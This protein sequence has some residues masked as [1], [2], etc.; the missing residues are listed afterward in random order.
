MLRYIRSMSFT[1]LCAL[2]AGLAVAVAQAPDVPESGSVEAIRAFTT[3]PRYLHPWVAYVPA[4]ASVPSPTGYLGHVVGAPGELSNAARIHGY[5]RALAAASP[6]VQVET[7]GRTEEGRDILLVA[8]ADEAG[9]R[10]LAAQKEALAAL[11]DPRRTT[12]EEAERL[13]ARSRPVYYFNAGL[14]ADETGSAE[15][16]MEL[17]YRLAV[18][19]MPEIQRIR[20]RVLVLI[21]PVSE[22]DGRDKM[23]DWFRR[24]LKGRTD[25]EALPRQSP[26]YWGKYVFVD[27]NR[28]AHQQAL[29]VTQAVHRMFFDY[30]PTVVHDLHEAIPLL[31]TWNGTGPFNPHID[32]IVISEMFALSFEEVRRMTAA[33]MPGVWTWD[34]GEGFGHH[35]LD[36]VAINHNSIGRG[37]ETFGNGTS[38][39]VRRTIDRSS[40]SREW[41][42]PHPADREITWSMRNNV[43]Y[44][45]TAALVALDYV[46]QNAR[47]M[48]RSFYRKGYN[49]WQR[50]LTEAPYGF[51]VRHDQPDRRRVAQM[52]DRLRLQRIEVGRLTAP[53]RLR[54][55]EFPVGTFVIRLDQPYRNYAV[56]LLTAQRFPA[57]SPHE[58]YDDISWALPIHYGVEVISTADSAVRSAPVQLLSGDVAVRGAVT[59]AGGVYLIAD[60]GQEG[61]LEARFRLRSF[62][63]EIAEAP[64]DVDGTRFPA[65]SWIVPPAEGLR[66]AMTTLARDLALDVRAVATAPDV[67]RHD[68]PVPRIGVWVPWADTDSIGWIRY[69][70]DQRQVP[71]VYL[72]DE[73]IRADALRSRVDVIVYGHVRLELAA[74]IRGI[75]AV[76]GPMPFT[77]TS[78]FPSHGTPAA[79]DDIT[80]GIGWQGLA[81]LQAFVEAGGVLV[82]LGNGSTL[83]LDSGL[84]PGMRR[85]TGRS[86]TTPGAAVRASFAWPEHPIAYG[87]GRTPVVF[88]SN[89]AA[90]D[91]PVRWNEMAYCTTC[92][93]GPVDRRA[94]VMT[95]GADGEPMIV[96]G[97]GRNPEALAGLPAIL[98]VPLGRGHVVVFNFNPIHR[99]LNRANHRFLWNVLLNWTALP[100]R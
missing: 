71:Y 47:E 98:D 95:W 84:L 96:S 44:Q 80:G 72:R 37:Y 60:R 50:G 99:D 43:N 13:I 9:L 17:A 25:Y 24:Y 35:Y 65:G 15:M 10:M 77:R 11:A 23:V 27:V 31:Q 49:S 67:R 34:F 16:S 30:F 53:L 82:T 61:L 18:S 86:F 83:A 41:F 100:G 90:Y 56:D 89:Y 12:P 62:R 39:T 87:F 97:G 79:S 69:A 14:H 45:Q 74:Q 22:P 92:L 93:R 91:L 73:D 36:S 1:T 54:E 78:E 66:D 5:L 68:A 48:L 58:P 40:L 64:F 70:L 28:D 81:A 51:L 88:R 76:S 21:N 3:D 85:A 6:R 19:E 32:P 63:V 59:G 29:A 4:S 42:R 8:I 20:E 7:I 57:D 75:D 33:G 38:E 94:V 26:P 46:A 52:I 55:G 2:A